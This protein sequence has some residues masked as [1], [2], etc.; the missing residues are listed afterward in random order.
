MTH[1]RAAKAQGGSDLRSSQASESY[2]GATIREG[3]KA[4]STSV[5][6]NGRVGREVKKKEMQEMALQ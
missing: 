2:G 4:R 5:K 3:A 6:H 1:A